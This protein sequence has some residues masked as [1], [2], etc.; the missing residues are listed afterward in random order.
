[1]GKST[2]FFFKNK[3]CILLFILFI[4]LFSI[5]NSLAML[6]PQEQFGYA[7]I[8]IK[9]GIRFILFNTLICILLFLVP[10]FISYTILLINTLLGIFIFSWNHFLGDIPTFSAIRSS[11]Q[12]NITQGFNIFSYIDKKSSLFLIISL[13]I[14]IFILS[15]IKSHLHIHK[16]LRT[17]G[18]IICSV[19]IISGLSFYMHRHGMGFTTLGQSI[20]NNILYRGYVATWF[21]EYSDPV[22][23]NQN[24]TCSPQKVSQIPIFPKS[25]KVVYIQVECLD[26]AMLNYQNND[27][28]VMPFISKISKKGMIFK[29]DG[30]KKLTSSNSDY[31]LLNTRVAYPGTVYY[32]TLSSYPDSI[33]LQFKNKGADLAFFH[34]LYDV[35]GM[36]KAYP[37]MGFDKLV[38]RE[39]LV[40]AGYRL[41]DATPQHIDD[42]DLFAY[43][44]KQIPHDKPFFHVIITMN[45]HD[46]AKNNI[47]PL[48]KGDADEGFFT[49]ARITDDGIRAYVESLPAG[50]DVLIMGDHTPYFGPRSVH[51]PLILYRTGEPVPMKSPDI[52]LTRC[53]AS[54]YLRR[55]FDLPPVSSDIPVVEEM[56]R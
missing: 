37:L 30:V 40:A 23:P 5:E 53:E 56:C 47:N 12:S 50:T 7:I 6:L 44:A 14:N 9:I 42:R 49:N 17:V 52:S 32:S 34:G 31:E 38:L 25:N 33:P 45:M 1:M 16:K 28:I 35:S 15:Y 11:I 4:I 27:N 19:L 29:I 48:F 41:N 51:V 39:E 43:A 8:Y 54:Q 21:A 13:L 36:R 20:Q 2:D 24:M 55:V 26:Y 22:K 18:I 3:K 46:P 10:R